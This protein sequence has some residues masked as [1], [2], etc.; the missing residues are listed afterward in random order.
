MVRSSGESFDQGIT[1]LWSFFGGNS[2]ATDIMISARK[3]TPKAFGRIWMVLSYAHM[4]AS[5]PSMLL[6]ALR[7]RSSHLTGTCRIS[8]HLRC[9]LEKKIRYIHQHQTTCPY[10]ELLFERHMYIHE[11]VPIVHCILLPSRQPR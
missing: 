8:F 5:K 4:R 3:R 1:H 9:Q 2:I 7:P 6:K 10:S 11:S